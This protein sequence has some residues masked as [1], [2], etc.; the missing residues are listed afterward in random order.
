MSLRHYLSRLWL[1][2]SLSFCLFA[3][4]L[5]RYTDAANR[6][7]FYWVRTDLFSLLFCIIAVGSIFFL[8]YIFFYLAGNAITRKMCEIFFILLTGIAAVANISCMVKLTRIRPSG[9]IIALGVCA[10]IFMGG[11]IIWLLLK[12]GRRIKVICMALCFIL[13]P[14]FPVFTLNALGYP[15]ITLDIG[16]MPI[17][18]DT[19]HFN[20]DSRNNVY[21]FIFDEWSYQRSFKNRRLQQFFPNLQQFAGQ[22]IVFHSAQAPSPNTATAIPSILYQ[23]NLKFVLQGSEMW[24]QGR[25]HHPL[26][27]AENIFHH[28]NELGFFTAMIGS[29]IPYGEMLGGTVDFCRSINEYKRFG[30]DFF[31]VAQYHLLTAALL[32]PAPLFHYQRK[33][34]ADYFFN[35]YR[36]SSIGATDNLF[37][38]TVKE[39]GLPALAVFHYMIPHLP[40]IFAAG[41]GH[42]DFF[43]VYEDN[44]LPGYYDNLAYTDRKIGEIITTLRKAGKFEESLIIFTT[45]HGWR[46]DPGYDKNEWWLWGRKIRH[47]PLFIKLPFQKQPVEIDTKFETFH[48]GNFIN[49][50]LGAHF[51]LQEAERLLREE[52]SFKP[53]PLEEEI[54]KDPGN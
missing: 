24:F 20:N 23:T 2:C 4:Y 26:D 36:V 3:P 10:W 44:D 8:C 16:D 53:R 41:G 25:E 11:C 39:Q 21:L 17:S 31:G 7:F 47:V 19:N 6:F 27:Q 49:R 35:K 38:K 42:K 12:H 28:A 54:T 14:L 29:A 51:D 45:D 46:F 32:L 18:A 34:I 15:S 52:N 13:S 22:A 1:A 30:D 43:T 33:L 50:Y 48:L 37:A 9:Y 40:Y 5:S